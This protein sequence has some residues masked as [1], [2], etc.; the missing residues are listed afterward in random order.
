MPRLG[1]RKKVT[2]DACSTFALGS[3]SAPTVATLSPKNNPARVASFI[4]NLPPISLAERAGWPGST[5][6]LS[7]FY[8]FLPFSGQQFG[9]GSSSPVSGQTYVEA[10]C[11]G[12]SA[13]LYVFAYTKPPATARD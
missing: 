11:S 12:L 7:L 4:T 13:G 3:S 10:V 5:Q 2:L 1:T 9:Q 6:I 8:Y